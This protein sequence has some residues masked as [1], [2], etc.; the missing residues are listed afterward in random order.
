MNLVQKKIKNP[1]LDSPISVFPPCGGSNWGGSLVKKVLKIYIIRLCQL[2]I[3]PGTEVSAGLG[4]CEHKLIW[5]PNSS[6]FVGIM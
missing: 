1:F 4:S 3:N 6:R 2:V 5:G